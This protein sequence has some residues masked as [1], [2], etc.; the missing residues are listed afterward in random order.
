MGCKITQFCANY[1]IIYYLVT[2]LGVFRGELCFEEEGSL[3]LSLT[4]KKNS[5][6]NSCVKNTSLKRMSTDEVTTASVEAFP[7]FTEPPS[8]V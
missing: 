8:T 3:T 6:D 1:Q 4:P 7:T 2:N 5:H